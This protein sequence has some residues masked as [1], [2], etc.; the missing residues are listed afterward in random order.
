[1]AVERTAP[2]TRTLLRGRIEFNSGMSTLDCAIRDLSD[3]GARLEL[4]DSVAMP[5]VFRLY[6]PKYE[7]W[8]D[9][10]TRWHRGVFVG[11]EFVSANTHKAQPVDTP[12]S[13]VARLEAE[14]VKLR[15]LVEEIR[16]DPSRARQLLE[17]YE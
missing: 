9:A 10:E 11:I 3:T 8:Y 13:K 7:R 1:M 5:G 2:R 15:K 17:T 16:A 12:D 4:G 6:I 14:V